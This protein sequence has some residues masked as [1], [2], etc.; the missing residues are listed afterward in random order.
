ME[1]SIWNTQKKSTNTKS[2]WGDVTSEPQQQVVDSSASSFI[3]RHVS[4]PIPIFSTILS[5]HVEMNKYLKQVI[6]E[7]RQKNPEDL[8]SNV[9]AWHSAWETHK[10]NP[11]FQPLVDRITSACK[12]ISKP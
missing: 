8:D 6:L 10:E 9:K 4:K 12:F 2:A 5:D 1:N 11:K 7:H 3:T